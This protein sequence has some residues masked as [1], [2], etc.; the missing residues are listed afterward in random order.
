MQITNIPFVD[1]VVILPL[2]T[3]NI[4]LFV[5]V[6]IYYKPRGIWVDLVT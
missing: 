5:E 6:L 1:T 3:L 4:V 2:K